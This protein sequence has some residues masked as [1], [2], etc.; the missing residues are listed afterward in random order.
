M[1][2]CIL[3]PFRRFVYT[4]YVRGSVKYSEA[5]A[6]AKSGTDFICVWD[7]LITDKA[8]DSTITVPGKFCVDRHRQK[9]RLFSRTNSRNFTSVL[10]RSS[11]P[12]SQIPANSIAHR[13]FPAMLELPRGSRNTL[14]TWLPGFSPFCNRSAMGWWWRPTDIVARCT[15]HARRAA[16]GALWGRRDRSDAPCPCGIRRCHIHCI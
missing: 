6:F 2:N 16:K 1:I 9:Q 3:V 11:D 13:G 14:S 8:K 5:T 10:H 7:K 12:R 4:R 15:P